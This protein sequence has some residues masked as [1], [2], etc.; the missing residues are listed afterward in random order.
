M[1]SNYKE[2]DFLKS[3]E[4]I[5]EIISSSEGFE[6]LNY[7]PLRNKLTYSNGFYVNCSAL[8][9]DIR[10][11]SSL[12]DEHR[13]PT[14]A[15][16]YRA[17]ISEIVAIMNGNDDCS[18]INIIGDCVSGIFD[19][20]K[21]VKI[22]G[23]V[24]TAARI[25]TI[26]KILNCKFVKKGIKKIKVGIGMSWGRALMIQAGCKGSTINDVVWMG[27]VVNEAAHLANLGNEIYASSGFH[28]NLNDHNKK[29]FHR[30][31][32]EKY[33]S[34]S[35]I[36]PKMYEWYEENCKEKSGWF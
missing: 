21:K 24:S 16:L 26:V 35:F 28:H 12:T 4:R 15:K 5:D 7:I 13:R 9:V 32:L 31:L 10:D 1:E 19:T 30:V 25:S 29:L 27:N 14:L 18:E 23:V 22:D 2:Y 11:S 3:L 34:G 33:Y 36:N 20:P 8:F 17:F 6:E